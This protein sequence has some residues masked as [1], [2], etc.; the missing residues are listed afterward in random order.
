M[1]LFT[2]QFFNNHTYFRLARWVTPTATTKFLCVAANKFRKKVRIWFVPP[3]AGTKSLLIGGPLTNFAGGEGFRICSTYNVAGKYRFE[4]P[5]FLEI[6]NY[7]GEI[8]GYA[9]VL[10]STVYYQEFGD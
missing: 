8:Y 10:G 5:D 1:P 9:D 7:Q 3:S 6:E 4:F 2:S